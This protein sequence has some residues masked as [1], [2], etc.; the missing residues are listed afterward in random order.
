MVIN[1]STNMTQE[2]NNTSLEIVNG[3]V[4]YTGGNTDTFAADINALFA[5]SEVQEVYVPA[6]TYAVGCTIEVPAN[7]ILHLAG[8][9][10]TEKLKYAVLSPT[11]S[12]MNVIKLGSGSVLRGGHIKLNSLA[13]TNAVYLPVYKEQL[14]GTR[15]DGTK[16][17]GGNYWYQN[18][19]I[20]HNYVASQRG[21]Y[22]QMD[23][24]EGNET[25]GYEKNGY[26]MFCEFDCEI[27]KVGVAYDA[28]RTVGGTSVNDVVWATACRFYGNLLYC[29]KYVNLDCD[30][31]GWQFDKS[32]IDV[33]IQ[34]GESG[35]GDYPAVTVSGT[36]IK[37]N[38]ELWDFNS[39]TKK[40]VKNA[41]GNIVSVNVSTQK[42]AL[43]LKKYSRDNV[44]YNVR[45]GDIISDQGRDNLFI[46]E[47]KEIPTTA[48]IHNSFIGA[49]KAFDQTLRFYRK[50]GSEIAVLPKINKAVIPSVAGNISYQANFN[51]ER[52]TFA[53]DAAAVE[54]FGLNYLRGFTGADYV[55]NN[56]PNTPVV[57]GAF[58]TDN[59]ADTNN[60]VYKC[61]Y[62]ID[63]NT[64]QRLDSV[65]YTTGNISRF[66]KISVY[67]KDYHGGTYLVGEYEGVPTN[68]GGP[69]LHKVYS[70]PYMHTSSDGVKSYSIIN[71]QNPYVGIRYVMEN[72]L[73][74]K[75]SASFCALLKPVFYSESLSAQK[76]NSRF[77][78][79]TLVGDHSVIHPREIPLCEIADYLASDGCDFVVEDDCVVVKK[80]AD[81]KCQYALSEGGWYDVN[82][83]GEAGD[84]PCRYFG[85]TDT[86]GG[87]VR[88]GI[89]EVC[90]HTVNVSVG[91]SDY[92]K[93]KLSIYYVGEEIEP[94][95]YKVTGTYSDV[96]AAKTIPA[97][98]KFVLHMEPVGEGCSMENAYE[99]LEM[100]LTA[101]PSVHTLR[102]KENCLVAADFDLSI[103]VEQEGGENTE[104]VYTL[105]GCAY[106][107]I[108][109]LVHT[110]YR[111]SD[112]EGVYAL[113]ENLA[114]RLASEKVDV[115]G[116]IA[117]IRGMKVWDL[118]GEDAVGA[119]ELASDYHAAHM[120]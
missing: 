102:V 70:V 84:I 101:T 85:A 96:K 22:M 2:M 53:N 62:D 69:M 94:G 58:D 41:A 31:S 108:L 116:T 45:R 20:T 15:V 83:P 25:D 74:N 8:N 77:I 5:M 115:G 76:R 117:V 73:T 103:E 81:V 80:A 93:Y 6:G 39:T 51:G 29:G 68:A 114:S 90:C 60:G 13:N 63:F 78:G 86:D 113:H 37:M 106:Y 32:D 120:R 104:P 64:R 3:R 71:K 65:G 10:K 23:D 112:L 35:I 16:I 88:Y 91:L 54:V 26:L 17:E 105:D 55:D 66:G 109:G 24:P 34:A 12:G 21:V 67:L 59:D 11:A 100:N 111:D 47:T 56:M 44:I 4:E 28:V 1:M 38:L 18:E 48:P 89:G 7:K 97:G 40:K 30:S 43:Y 50:G 79:E 14:V 27:S 72:P 87:T 99:T 52:A 75:D 9:Y 107:P 95:K 110:K 19:E 36:G 46:S 42:T 49:E 92:T 118:E 33:M 82:L 98:T 57:K 119:Y 61:V